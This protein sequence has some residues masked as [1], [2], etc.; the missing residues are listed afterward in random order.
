M[1]EERFSIFDE[2]MT[3]GS[4]EVTSFRGSILAKL[5]LVW[6][7]VHKK[8]WHERSAP[9]SWIDGRDLEEGSSILQ[10]KIWL[11]AVALRKSKTKF[12]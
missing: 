8:V 4:N 12:E 3:P 6:S 11:C 5:A 2:P 7:W 9:N 1:W 10:W